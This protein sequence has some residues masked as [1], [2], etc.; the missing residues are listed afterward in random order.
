MARALGAALADIIAQVNAV[1]LL[2]VEHQRA[3]VL[4]TVASAVEPVLVA[5]AD[6]R[7]L[8]A[9]DS[10]RR[11][12]RRDVGAGLPLASIADWFTDPRAAA[13]MLDTVCR[14][15]APWRGELTLW[16]PAE[17]G[18]APPLP[19]EV[20]AEVVPTRDGR[21]LGFILVFG[22]R[23]GPHR[24]ADARAHLEEALVRAGFGAAAVPARDALTQ[25]ILA[26]AS[27]A[28][29]D[30]A[31]ADTASPVA[32]LLAELEASMQRATAL[33]ARIRGF[34]RGA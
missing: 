1:R 19:V 9:N 8:F 22:D 17:G 23:S 21:P 7:V 16:P 3:Q 4:A 20:R 6:R 30:V 27:L 31:D 29:M 18:D 34:S 2:I 32:G 10:L 11:L 28:A 5:D 25:A 26:N 15:H 13:R 14:G 24:A 12:V 33:V